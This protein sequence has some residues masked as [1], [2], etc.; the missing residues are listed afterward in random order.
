MIDPLKSVR[1]VVRIIALLLVIG[2]RYLD[3]QAH[4]AAMSGAANAATL[5]GLA[6]ACWIAAVVA[7]IV[8]FVIRVA[9]RSR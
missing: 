4:Q 6:A 9:L 2:A 3:T 7:I 8:S 5:D 1:T